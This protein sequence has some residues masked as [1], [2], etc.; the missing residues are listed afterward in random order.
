MF[1]QTFIVYNIVNRV[2]I[3]IHQSGYH[4]YMSGPQLWELFYIRS[5][6]NVTRMLTMCWFYRVVLVYA[7]PVPQASKRPVVTLWQDPGRV[8]PSEHLV[9][10]LFWGDPGLVGPSEHLVV[11]LFWQDPERVGPFGRCLVISP[12]LTGPLPPHEAWAGRCC[13]QEVPGRAW[14][15]HSSCRRPGVAWC[16]PGRVAWCPPGRVPSCPTGS[17]SRSAWNAGSSSWRV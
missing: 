15:R 10:T 3:K 14:S 4:K 1:D 7:S 13:A 17:S 6:L 11:T 5:M 16:P 9:V 8:G 2:Y 12:A